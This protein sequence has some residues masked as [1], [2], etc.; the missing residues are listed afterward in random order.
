MSG[1]IK[2]ITWNIRGLTEYSKASIIRRWV[3]TQTQRC[4]IVCLQE[5]KNSE[6]RLGRQL[7]EIISEENVTA[8]LTE[9][10]RGGSAVIV[11]KSMLILE[12]GVKGDAKRSGP[13]FTRY[14]IRRGRLDQ[15]RTDRVYLSSSGTWLSYVKKVEHV[16]RKTLS[17]R[18]PVVV[19]LQMTNDRE[20]PLRQ[21]TYFKIDYH[22]LEAENVYREV[23]RMWKDHPRTVLDPRVKWIMAWRRLK[24]LFKKIQKE[25]KELV[26]DLEGKEDELQALRIQAEGNVTDT[27]MARIEALEVEIR[28]KE[29][30]EADKWRKN[31]RN[32]WLRGGEAP[33][34]YFFSQLKSKHQKESIKVLELENGETLTSES[35]ILKEIKTFH[36]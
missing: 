16:G 23:E 11:D 3:Q 4:L 32:K 20:R 9:E 6:E 13:K 36:S 7:A 28:S 26:R 14:E 17:D 15:S 24:Q 21:S 10:A 8:D 33:S 1:S 35:E 5:V 18:I 27:L 22:I 34:K 29:R 2:I 19:T 12:S 31:S 25:K 30:A